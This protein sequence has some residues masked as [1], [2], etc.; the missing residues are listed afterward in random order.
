MAYSSAETNQG[1]PFGGLPVPVLLQRDQL[2]PIHQAAK[3]PVEDVVVPAVAQVADDHRVD[4]VAL[5]FEA[6]QV[7]AKVVEHDQR[8]GLVSGLGAA[9]RGQGCGGQHLGRIGLEPEP[10]EAL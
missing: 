7:L 10:L 5:L 3:G 2:R 6:L 9:L 1:E 8:Y 4:R